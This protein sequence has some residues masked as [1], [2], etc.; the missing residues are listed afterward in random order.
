MRRF[1][2][3]SVLFV[4]AT[5]LACDEDPIAPPTTGSLTLKFVRADEATGP[6]ALQQVASVELLDQTSVSTD[7]GQT[8]K[9]PLPKTGAADVTPR[10]ATFVPD[11]VFVEG[12][13][14]TNSAAAAGEPQQGP[15]SDAGARAPGAANA[16]DAARI[17]IVGQTPRVLENQ[18]PG[19]DITVEG[20]EPGPYTVIFEGLVGGEVDYYGTASVT[21]VAGDNRTATLNYGSFRPTMNAFTS[22]TTDMTFLVSFQQAFGAED[23]FVEIDTDPAFSAPFFDTVIAERSIAIWVADAGTYYARATAINTTA[24]YG[25]PGDAEAIVVQRDQDAS[26]DDRVGAAL[27]GFSPDLTL[28]ELNIAPPGDEDWFAVDACLGDVL[29]IE[30]T[31]QRLDP[32]SV[33]DTYIDLFNETQ[34]D[35]IAFNDDTYGVDSYLEATLP[36]GGRYYVRVRGPWVNGPTGHYDLT[37]SVTQG[38]VNDGTQCG[39]P[40][41]VTN[42]WSGGGDGTSWSAPANWLTGVPTATDTVAIPATASPILSENVTVAGLIIAPG[43]HVD[44]DIYSLTVSGD[45]AAGNSITG[46]GQVILTGTGV[47]LSGGLPNLYVLGDVSL[48]GQTYATGTVQIDGTLRMNG[49][50]MAVGGWFGTFNNTGVLEM[51]SDADTLAVAGEVTFAGG[52]TDGML[53]AGRLILAGGIT[54]Q[55]VSPTFSSGGTHQVVM[56]GAADRTITDVAALSHFNHLTLHTTG[57]V[58]IAGALQE[59]HVA[60]TLISDASVTPTVTGGGLLVLGVAVQ[61]MVFDNAPFTIFEGPPITTFDG[62]VFT[63]FP[64][65]VPQLIVTRAGGE[66]TFNNLRFSQ[67]NGASDIYVSA[68]DTDNADGDQLTLNLAAASP[69]DGTPGITNT[70]DAIVNWVAAQAGDPAQVSFSV[71]PSSVAAG[72]AISPAIE[73]TIQDA[74]TI[75]VDTSTANVT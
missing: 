60:G 69:S 50:Q 64:A 31:A 40:E 49:H 5:L 51:K 71:Q 21:V 45:L 3:L 55:T 56:A 57:T 16:I 12:N 7:A 9:T 37:I 25:R 36:S 26:G 29:T 1:L 72:T 39:I 53:T 24:G 70:T 2:L 28:D 6:L 44:T 20:L 47:T 66:F 42:L 61:N 17:R 48:A 58:T 75:T 32:Q 10:I 68:T 14:P 4:A 30:T 22:P 38:P 63:N 73:V 8:D 35:S 33:L 74:Q 15:A 67:A 23:Y 18:T 11:P 41:G 19:S 13:T 62:I 54:A 65:S 27:L 59:A 43:G 46:N 52:S 34:P